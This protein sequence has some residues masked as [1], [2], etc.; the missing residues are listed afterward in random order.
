MLSQDWPAQAK[1]Y[2]E[3]VTEPSPRL[4]LWDVD[5]TL[6]HNGGVSKLAYALGFQMLT[7]HPPSE[8]VI[9]DG[10][11]DPAIMRSL[12]PATSP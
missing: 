4:V 1:R 5:G 12:S 9:T 3:A 6:I 2:R 11:T 10:M 8:P 7:G